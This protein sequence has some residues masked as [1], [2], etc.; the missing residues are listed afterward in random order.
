MK[1]I[2]VSFSEFYKLIFTKHRRGHRVFI[3]YYLLALITHTIL[4]ILLFHSLHYAYYGGSA[5]SM[6]L[7]CY[8]VYS[9]V[10]YAKV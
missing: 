6:S 1:T 4:K 2:N 3:I 7:G 10:G 8:I 9:I 5:L